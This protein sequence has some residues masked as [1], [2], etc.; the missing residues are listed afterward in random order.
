V[1]IAG[2]SHGQ[3]ALMAISNALVRLHKESYGRG[4]TSARTYIAGDLCVCVLRGGYTRGELML[5]ERGETATLLEHR[6]TVQATI[7]P[8]ARQI[9]EDSLGRGVISFMS[10]ND[11]GNDMQV[12]VFVLGD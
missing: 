12:E 4:P 10:A 5:R 11:P 8:L 7:E 2:D 3:G 9:V 1:S 6:L